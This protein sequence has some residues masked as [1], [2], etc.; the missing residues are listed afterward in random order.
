MSRLISR[1]FL[2][3]LAFSSL[4][5]GQLRAKDNSTMSTAVAPKPGAPEYPDS[6]RGL[7]HLAKDILNAQ[8]EGKEPRA[9]ELA[10]SM[11]LPDPAAWYLQTFGPYIA[12]DEGAKYAASQKGL[13][14]EILKFFFGAIDEHGKDVTLAECGDAGKENGEESA[15]R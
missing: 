12:N 13:P 7:E 4:A 14:A 15:F 8:K 6:T 10:Q 5:A 9:M 11:V 1:A 3:G 2:I